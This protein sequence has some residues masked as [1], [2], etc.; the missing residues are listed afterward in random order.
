M[1]NT[2]LSP[3][4]LEVHELPLVHSISL[5]NNSRSARHYL[6]W[7]PGRHCQ[8]VAEAGVL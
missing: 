5:G 7:K 3:S 4:P 8:Y 1:E 2:T 6:L